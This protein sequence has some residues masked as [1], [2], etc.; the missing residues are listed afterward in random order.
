[1]IPADGAPIRSEPNHLGVSSWNSARSVMR[2]RSPRSAASPARRG[3]STSRSRRSASRCIFWK[4][5]SASR[6]SGGPRAASDML[7]IGMGSGMA[8]IF[9]PRLFRKPILPGV[10][11]D[12]L[13]AP[14]KTIF[15]DLHEERLDAGIAIESDPDRVPAGLVYHRLTQAELALIVH[16]K[17]ALARS[18]RAVDVGRL[19]AE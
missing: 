7:V 11:L 15:N 4:R 9:I 12:I 18:R 8:Q 16:P 13:T 19:V 3:G 2:C 1:M 17:H 10:R 6:C 14:T 5:R